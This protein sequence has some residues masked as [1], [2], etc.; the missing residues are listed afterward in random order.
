VKK[1]HKHVAL[2]VAGGVAVLG[3]GGYLLY[4][5]EHPTTTVSLPGGKTTPALPANPNITPQNAN[6]TVDTGDVSTNGSDVA[7]GSDVSDPAASIVANG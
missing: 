4:K 5:H 6:P 2:A 1:K 3:I 7:A